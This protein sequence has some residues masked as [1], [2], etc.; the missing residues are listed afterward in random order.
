MVIQVQGI[1][2]NMIN[3]W[4]RLKV[5]LP[6]Q[7]LNLKG[8]NI[9]KTIFEVYNLIYSIFDLMTLK[10]NYFTSK[11]NF[12]DNLLKILWF[13]ECRALPPT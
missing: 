5:L 3:C 7:I 13:Y 1:A 8:S 12:F 9:V 10:L 2:P 6:L 11:Y 4:L